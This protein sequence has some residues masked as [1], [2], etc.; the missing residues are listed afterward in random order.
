MKA[1]LLH[2]GLTALLV[3]S[4]LAAYD[5]WLG[6]EADGVDPSIRSRL[7]LDAALLAR[8]RGTGRP[9]K[10]ERRQLD[11]FLEPPTSNDAG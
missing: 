1:M 7:A 8:E 9:T 11:T 2:A 10:R 5:R 3:A 4:G 6:S